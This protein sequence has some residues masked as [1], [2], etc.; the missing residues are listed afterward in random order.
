M[1]PVTNYEALAGYR[2]AVIEMYARVRN[3][4]KNQ[5]ER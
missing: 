1:V 2:R 5:K 3:S 4:D